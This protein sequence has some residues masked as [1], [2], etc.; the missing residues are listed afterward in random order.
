MKQAKQAKR[1]KKCHKC[2]RRPE[3]KLID[4]W[5]CSRCFCKLVE[6]KIRQ[7]LRKYK[8]K[9]DSKLF[10][11]DKASEYILRKVVN[12]P[13]QIIRRKQ[14]NCHIVVPWTIDDENEEFIKMFIDNTKPKKQENKTVIKLFYPLSKEDMKTY[15][16]I[17]KINY[18]P[19]KTPINKALDKFEQ[20]YPGTKTGLLKSEERLNSI[21]QHNKP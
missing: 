10:V 13:V 1:P 9:K 6:N 14:K 19:A 4:K 15:F 21:I 2:L 5:Y 8:I 20:K 18:N 16:R 11:A 3:H 12:V 7:N 17:N